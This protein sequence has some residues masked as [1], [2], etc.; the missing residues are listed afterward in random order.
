LDIASPPQVDVYPDD[1]PPPPKSTV[2]AQEE[3]DRSTCPNPLLKQLSVS[4]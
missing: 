1:E 2:D 3:N 4:F